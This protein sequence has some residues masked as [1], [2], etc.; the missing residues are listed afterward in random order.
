MNSGYVQVFCGN[1]DGKSSAAIGKGILSAI[2]GKD[3]ILV[4]FMKEKNE[5]ETKFF[6]RLEPEIKL[7]RFEKNDISFNELS[8]EGKKEEITNIRNGLNYAKKALSIGECDVLILDEVLGLVDEGIIKCDD[9]IPILE[10]R[11][12]EVTVILTGIV[13]PEEL[14]DYVDVVSEIEALIQ[15]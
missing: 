6:Q 12:E 11:T 1:G 14:K 2:D 3:V 9:L 8:E 13:M 15:K 5:N 4:Q 10:A 7:F